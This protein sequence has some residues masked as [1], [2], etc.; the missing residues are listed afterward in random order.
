MLGRGNTGKAT[1]VWGQLSFISA[2]FYFAGRESCSRD[3]V[4]LAFPWAF[5]T[6]ALELENLICAE[7][8]WWWKQLAVQSSSPGCPKQSSGHLWSLGA[9]V[10]CWK[11]WCGEPLLISFLPSPSYRR[12]NPPPVITWDFYSSLFLSWCRRGTELNNGFWRA[13]DRQW[14]SC[15]II[16]LPE[17]GT[18]RPARIHAF[19]GLIS[20]EEKWLT[21]AR[22]FLAAILFTESVHRGFTN[23][24]G[25]L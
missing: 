16:L 19:A 13:K 17:P 7:A 4:L 9:G 14:L 2:H 24:K 6:D 22:Y 20:G 8:P 15:S 12:M 21:Q 10:R 1:V 5:R 18:H 11:L 3:L 25:D 23:L